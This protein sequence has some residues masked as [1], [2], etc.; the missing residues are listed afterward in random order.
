MNKA[1][2]VSAMRTR[3]KRIVTPDDPR[4]LKN[5]TEIPE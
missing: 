5:T 3:Q 4:V 1:Y 2:D